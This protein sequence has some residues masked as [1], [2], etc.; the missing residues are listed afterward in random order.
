M[1]G[2][3]LNP[4]TAEVWIGPDYRKPAPAP[5]PVSIFQSFEDTF[6]HVGRV[7]RD[8]IEQVWKAVRSAWRFIPDEVREQAAIDA[9]RRYWTD[10]RGRTR[11]TRGA[12]PLL[13]NGRKPRK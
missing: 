4:Q 10:Q 8:T 5:R 6:R 2:E 3:P 13:H 1:T 9:G 12:R 7:M 11:R